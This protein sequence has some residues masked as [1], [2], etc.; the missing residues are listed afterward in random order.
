M[1]KYLSL[2]LFLLVMLMPSMG[3]YAKQKTTTTT[4]AGQKVNL[5]VFYDNSC[6][7]C[8]NLHNYI[9]NTLSKNKK[10]NYMYELV[11]L[12]V[13]DS[14]NANLWSLVADKFNFSED[15]RNRVPV[16]VIGEQYFI[17][18]NVETSP[19]KIETA[20]EKAYKQKQE[21]VVAGLAN[22]TITVPDKNLNEPET[23]SD[24]IGIVILFIIGI[25]V[26]GIIYSSSKT[27]VN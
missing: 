11:D 25:I 5:Y 2:I 23:N 24:T 4:K 20:I 18:F 21:D 6:S 8:A 19:E 9:S 12:D 7:N 14:D 22:G 10:Y 13:S 3:V 15:R 1:K 17:G 27:K 16:Y 26:I